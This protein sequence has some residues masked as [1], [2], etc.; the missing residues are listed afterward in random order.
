MVNDLVEVNSVSDPLVKIAV[1]I[2]G[3]AV[4]N[5]SRKVESLAYEQTGGHIVYVKERFGSGV[6]GAFDGCDLAAF[7]INGVGIINERDG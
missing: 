5:S 1:A 2:P 7:G 3:G 6:G 4:G